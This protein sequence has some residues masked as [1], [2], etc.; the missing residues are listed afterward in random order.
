MPVLSTWTLPAVA[1][2]PP[3]PPRPKPMLAPEPVSALPDLARLKL[4][5]SPPSPPPPPMLCASMPLEPRPVELVWPL[6]VRM[7]PV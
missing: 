3:E 4:I 7:V 6:L 2:M 1:P 5:A